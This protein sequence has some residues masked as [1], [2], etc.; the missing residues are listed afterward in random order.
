[1][2][3]FIIVAHGSPSFPDGP[4]STLA[5]LANEVRRY[6]P[7]QEVRSATLAMPGSLE[8]A[9]A[10]LERPK[11][12]PFF[13]ARGW[14][15]GRE[16][17]RRLKALGAKA[18]ILLPFGLEPQL[19]AIIAQMLRETFAQTGASEAILAA[20]GSKVARNS[21]DTAYDMADTLREAFGLTTHV[22][23]IEEAPYLSDVALAHPQAV[24]LPFFA[25][26][27]GH[28][29]GDIPQAL[30]EAS[31]R[32]TLLPAVGESSAVAELIAHSLREG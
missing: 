11:I 29:E 2:S 3:A 6:A 9:L 13:M 20:H 26:R 28:V 10:G 8:R 30:S 5:T 12:Y 16:L 17:P 7:G 32:G 22:G 24:C 23:L 21:K 31:F 15:V 4:E 18:E 27:A 19:P 14:F 25:L 1:M